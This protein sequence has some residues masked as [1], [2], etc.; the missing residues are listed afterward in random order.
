VLST[1]QLLLLLTIAILANV[2]LMAGIVLPPFFGRRALFTPDEDDADAMSAVDVA[3][4]MAAAQVDAPPE[5][6][7]GLTGA[8]Y[9]KVVRIV[10]Y[11]FLVVAA[12][13]VALT[14]AW[15]GSAP[16]IYVLL[17]TGALFVL[18]VHDLLPSSILGQ[19]KFVLEGSA[20]IAFFTVLIALTGGVESPFFFGYYL[21]IAAAALVVAGAANY[22]LAAVISVVYLLTLAGLPGAQDLSQVQLLEVAFRLVAL[23]LLSYLASVVA[24]EQRHTR[25]AA[26]RLSLYDPLTRLYN[27]SYFY[28]VM[29]REIQRAGRTGR[30]FCLLMVDLDRL[31]PINDEH[32]HHAGDRVLREVAGVIRRGIRG[33][34]AGAR[35]GGDEFMVLLPE[36]ELPGAVVL[37]D[38]LR[39]GVSA[40]RVDSD[41]TVIRPSISVGVVSYPDDG[42]AGDQLLVR[43]DEAMYLAKKEGRA[44]VVTLREPEEPPPP[45]PPPQRRRRAARGGAGTTARATTASPASG[46]PTAAASPSASAASG[47]AGGG[48]GRAAAA[49]RFRL[50]RQD[51]PHFRRTI[52][53]FI[54]EGRTGSTLPEADEAAPPAADDQTPPEAHDQPA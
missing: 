45:P 18:F 29:E 16:Y 2:V 52:G 6:R 22:L 26:L 33:I 23:W 40:L 15:S 38:K 9:D 27:R 10:A 50:I 28:A 37:A 5:A 8:A 53:Q 24:A 32:G 3:L 39:G 19:G 46:G 30:G 42:T 49:R 13:M 21:I 54:S 41:G 47:P 36:T 17:A 48:T 14:E 20:A 44:R 25:D 51:D 43:A 31:K 12:I 4:Q 34:D 7:A 11:A 35:L 1:D